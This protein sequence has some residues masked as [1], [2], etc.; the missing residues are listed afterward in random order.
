MGAA[1]RARGARAGARGAR[2]SGPGSRGGS[3]CL[4]QGRPGG[5]GEWRSA[6]PA[7]EHRGRTAPERGLAASAAAARVCGKGPRHDSAPHGGGGD[8][9]GHPAL[10]PVS[11]RLSKAS[12]T[13]FLLCHGHL[14]F[15]RARRAP[16]SPARAAAAAAVTPRR[17]IVR[18]AP[19]TDGA[20]A[21]PG[22]SPSP[23]V[24]RTSPYRIHSRI[25]SSE[26][27]SFSS[28]KTRALKITDNLENFRSPKFLHQFK[29][30]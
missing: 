6:D 22:F 17:G 15:P 2:P 13:P 23:L 18:A 16:P 29:V 24:P 3:R 11:L 12:L 9:A 20:P 5:G 25:Q 14:K 27:S 28:R 19:I 10:P 1:A 7:P 26:S 30:L 8:G 4:P 21:G